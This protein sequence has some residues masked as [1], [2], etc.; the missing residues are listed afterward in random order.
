MD[1]TKIASSGSG[2]INTIV[3]KVIFWREWDIYSFYILLG[4][5]GL[6]I[7][8]FWVFKKAAAEAAPKKQS[9]KRR[10]KR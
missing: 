2:I 10:R 3:K 6:V 8:T 7:F 4:I 1:F 9:F 5:I